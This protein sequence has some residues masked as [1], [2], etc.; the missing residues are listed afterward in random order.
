MR[1]LK[2]GP[3]NGSKA[4]AKRKRM[5]VT[6]HPITS[7]NFIY[8]IDDPPQILTLKQS[9]MSPPVKR[10]GLLISSPCIP[11]LTT[12]VVKGK[13]AIFLALFMATVSI[14]WC[15]AQLPLILLG[16]IFPRSVVN[17]RSDFESL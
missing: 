11:Y 3:I 16:M 5:T 7:V 8:P 2:K 12:D 4:K 1:R 6:A 14:L 13:R 10:S 9:L 15:F 17:I